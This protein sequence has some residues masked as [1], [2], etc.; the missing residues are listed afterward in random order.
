MYCSCLGLVVEALAW[1]LCGCLVREISPGSPVDLDKRIRK[2]TNYYTT[3]YLCSNS[4]HDFFR[5]LTGN[6]QTIG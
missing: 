2:G 3:S 6:R 4:Y 1:D 5:T